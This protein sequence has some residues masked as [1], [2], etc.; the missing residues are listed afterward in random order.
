MKQNLQTVYLQ[1]STAQGPAECRIFA[2][3][4]LGRL[5]AEAKAEG[6]EAEIISETADKHGIMSAVL[7]LDCKHAETLAQ[8]WQGSLQWICASPVR[9]KHPR[10][11]WYIGVFRMPDMP[12]M[13]SESE[14]EFQTCR[15]GGKG[16]QHVNKTGGTS[17]RTDRRLRP[18][19]AQPAL[20]GG[21]RQ[22]ETDVRRNNFSGKAGLSQRPS[23]TVFTV[24]SDGLFSFVQY[25]S[26]ICLK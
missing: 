16:G 18:R 10:K 15:S 3:F 1:I 22:S 6:V 25:E 4:V 9:P 24:V 19:T 12:E 20:S 23:K 14:I 26:G 8:R 7:K 5:L 21:T 13:P 2:R 17:C 11:N